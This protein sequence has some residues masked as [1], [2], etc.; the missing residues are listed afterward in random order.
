MN[1]MTQKELEQ[2]KLTVERMC[3]ELKAK[4]LVSLRLACFLLILVTAG[5]F[6]TSKQKGFAPLLPPARMW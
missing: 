1:G 5:A 6:K 4:R 2:E 3:L